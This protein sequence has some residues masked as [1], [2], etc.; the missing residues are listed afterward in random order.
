MKEK[1]PGREFGKHNELKKLVKMK[2]KI[3]GINLLHANVQS[4]EKKIS[5]GR[6]QHNH[7]KDGD[8]TN[9]KRVVVM[10]LLMNKF[11]SVN[12]WAL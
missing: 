2:M 12:D 7:L 3:P 9:P 8:T 11:H 10:I 6:G 1:T 5:L 4:K